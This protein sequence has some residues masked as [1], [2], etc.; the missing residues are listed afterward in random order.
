VVTRPFPQPGRLVQ[1][2]YRE[3]MI[4]QYGT[5]EE[6]AA[7]GRIETLDRPWDP[8]SCAPA[9]R[10]QVWQWL[11]AVA[12]WVNHEYAWTVDRL[13]P[14]C[15]PA[16]P[17]LAHELAVLADQRRA[18]GQGTGSDRLEDWHRYS[19]PMFTDR[20]ASRL[21]T[22]CVSR[23]DEWPAAARHRA[24][25]SHPNQQARTAWFADDLT[26]HRP[27]LPAAAGHPARLALLDLGTGEV[28][29]PGQTNGGR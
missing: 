25:H 1:A 10:Q 26:T 19:L 29:D 2:A 6:R 16:H 14:P 23:H 7:L 5:D 8:P 21:G 12:A 27:A 9:V 22:G 20:L 18:A 3:L 13:I 11:D 28:T 15:W 24:Y 4:A 17:H